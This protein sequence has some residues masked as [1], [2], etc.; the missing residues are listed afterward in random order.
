MKIDWNKVSDEKKKEVIKALG[1]GLLRLVC[2]KLR[3]DYY[4]LKKRG[5]I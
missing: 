3:I 4:D 5:I 1:D 2:R